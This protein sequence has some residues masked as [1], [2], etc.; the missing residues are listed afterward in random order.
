M[1]IETYNLT[2]WY[3]NKIGCQN[4]CLSVSEGQ[5]FG[6]LGHN[7]AGKSTLVKMLVGL[8]YPSAGEATIFRKP[9]GNPET[10]KMIGFLPENFRYH[11]WLTGYELL[12]FH[13]ALYHISSREREK[14][15]REVLDLLGL[16]GHEHHKIKTY[17]KGMQQRLGLAG[18]LLP[19]PDLLILD[20]PTSAMDPLGRKEIRDLILGLKSRGKTIFLN[21][22]LLSEM[23]MVC[24]HVALIKKGTMIAQGSI[25]SL[26][27]QICEVEMQVA[28]LNQGIFQ[29]ISG[30]GCAYRQENGHL[31]VTVKTKEQI[32]YLVESVVGNGG[33][34]YQLQ[35]R[36]NSLEE[37]FLE[38]MG[39]G[40]KNLADNSS[41][42]R[43][44]NI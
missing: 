38:L 15:I 30:M 43:E 3:G 9:L 44:R 42:S 22:H 25:H 11:D 7:G 5:V 23:E 33:K 2:K 28:G 20:E 6:F 8:I 36:H 27:G 40:G 35:M 41:T 1:V 12:H 14:R 29:A 19:D 10:K 32:P 39:D 18:A 17:S 26:L 34:L 16:T 21:S 37:L 31:I 4:I 24:D 13:G